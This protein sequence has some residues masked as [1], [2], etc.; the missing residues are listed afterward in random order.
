MGLSHITKTSS[1]KKDIFFL[2]LFCTLSDL[3]KAVYAWPTS[4]VFHC[5]VSHTKPDIRTPTVT[6]ECDRVIP[7]G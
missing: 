2:Y 3:S 5:L 4:Y 7:R 6:A 1:E